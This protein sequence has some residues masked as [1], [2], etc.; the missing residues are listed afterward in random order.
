MPISTVLSRIVIYGLP[1]AFVVISWAV[2]A[3]LPY[4]PGQQRDVSLVPACPQP[5]DLGPERVRLADGRRY[6][7]LSPASENFYSH[8]PNGPRY[9]HYLLLRLGIR[10]LSAHVLIIGVVAAGLMASAPL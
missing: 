9:L 5:R 4:Y 7:P 2:S 6:R 3:G 10:E 8:N 1:L